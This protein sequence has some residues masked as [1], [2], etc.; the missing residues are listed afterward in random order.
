MD[1]VVI[2]STDSKDLGAVRELFQ[3][4]ANSLGI[5][6]GFQH[7]EQELAELPGKYAPQSGW[8]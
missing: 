6:L 3:E 4:Y 2:R 5:D 8:E 7:F 1:P